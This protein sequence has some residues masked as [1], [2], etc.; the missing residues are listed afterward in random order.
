[1]NILQGL[2]T[3]QQAAVTQVDGPLL[4]L[5]GAGSG[6]TRVLT[7]RIAYL[8]EQG[9]NPYNIL[10]VTFT[11]KAAK[12]MKDRVERLL[13]HTGE[14]LWIGTFHSVCVRILRREI[15]K[16]GYKSNFVIYDDSDQ[17]TVVKEAMKELNIDPKSVNPRAVLGAISNAKNELVRP[18]TYAQGALGFFES[19]VAKV[20]TVYQK[21]LKANN[22]ADFDDLIMLTVELLKKFEPVKEYYQDKFKF[23]LVDEYQDTNHSQYILVKLL[24][25]KYRNICVVGDPDQSIYGFRGADIRNILS[26]EQDYPE[27]KVVKLEQNYRSTGNILDAAHHVIVKNTER[28][29]KRLWTAKDKGENL[30]LFRT[31]SDKEEA[32]YVVSQILNLRKEHSYD[33]SNFAILYRTNAQS[34][35]L[36]DALMQSRV[37]YKVVGGLKF[38]D[39]MEV[40]DIIAYLRLIYNTDDDV[41]FRR[42]INR[43]RRGIGDTSVERLGEYAAEAGISMFEAAGKVND[44]AAVRGKAGASMLAFYKMISEFTAVKDELRVTE[45]TKKLLDTS[46]YLKELEGENTIEAQSRIENIKELISGMEEY[47]RS[48]QGYTLGSYLEDVALVSDLD[49]VDDGETGVFLMTV[50]TVKGLEFPVVFLTGMEEMVFPHSRSIEEPSEMEEERRLCYVG[51]TRAMERLFVTFSLSRMTFGQ[52][53]N[54]PPSRFIRDIPPELFGFEVEEEPDNSL[55]YVD[56]DDSFSGGSRR[57]STGL[58]MSP[59]T[60]KA[61]PTSSFGSGATGGGVVNNP[62]TMRPGTMPGAGKMPGTGGITSTGSIP[63]AGATGSNAISGT[64]A[65]PGT[66]TIR[67]MG[68]PPGVGARA[69]IDRENMV[70]AANTVPGAS[71]SDKFGKYSGGEKVKHPK[72]GIG[73]VVGVRGEGEGQELDILF[74]G[75]G[76]KKLLVA[77]APLQRV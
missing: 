61:A 21:L 35:V 44:I 67:G 14:G 45:L 30:T 22:A 41:S 18:E 28:K 4:I 3:E 24:A 66:G 62:G 39:R 74:P 75:T 51:I 72:F 23:I 13:D 8:I 71:K 58:T 48:G 40:K 1:M 42:I 20:Y 55:V 65:M 11:N 69:G 33:Y 38:Y 12:E 54:N 52:F 49:T 27:A 64:G 68:T 73:T 47:I 36:E 43:P 63:G 10:A 50:H 15:E 37:P 59:H 7:H 76:V 26:F 25:A 16:L 17:L 2:N 46:G 6:K 9:I 31:N 34:R 5:A 77:Y 56:D 29:D 32:F 53:K 19:H 57:R 60:S 70:S